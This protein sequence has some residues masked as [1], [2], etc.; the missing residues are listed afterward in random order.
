MRSV[1]VSTLLLLVV[2]ASRPAWGNV[3]E[4]F[5]AGVRS[6]SMAGAMSATASD[7]TAAWHNPAALTLGHGSMGVAL[8][9]GVDRT[10]IVLTPRPQGYA[11]P[12]YQLRLRPRTDTETRSQLTGVLV[13]LALEL[14]SEDLRAAAMLYIPREGFSH[15]QT[16]FADE[17]EQHFSNQLHFELLGERLRS[18]VIAAALAYRLGPWISVGIGLT[19]LPHSA[20]DASVYT[21]NAA[22]PAHVEMNTQIEQG[23]VKSLTAGVLVEPTDGLRFAV[24]FVDESAFRVRGQTEVQINGQQELDEYPIHQ[25]LGFSV[26][27]S[28]PLFRAG[29]AWVRDTFLITVEGT[30]SVW[31]RYRDSHDGDAGL[32]DTINVRA[33]IEY[34]RSAGTFLRAGLGWL[35]SPVPSQTGRTSYVDNDRL[36]FSAGAGK[37]FA[38]WNEDLQIDFAIQVQALLP[39]EAQKTRSPDGTYAACASDTTA[40]CDEIID[41]AE[42]SSVYEAWETQGLQTGNPGFPGYSSGGYVLLSG[43]ELKWLF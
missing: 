19:L 2:V 32:D 3:C 41:Q 24:S 25:P 21:P 23:V 34:E 26:H 27:V 4:V 39:R 6:Q 18:E 9:A 16:W 15:G 29:A 5:G 20:T 33:A 28:P 36:V 30:Y 11:P 37:A 43:V 13:G 1:A 22:D 31:S 12:G 40:L 17:R 42:D 35:P 14:F 7:Y 8:L 10:S 38:L